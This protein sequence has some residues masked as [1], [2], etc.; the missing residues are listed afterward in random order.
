M[1]KIPLN[2]YPSHQRFGKFCLLLTS[3]LLFLFSSCKKDTSPIIEEP[4]INAVEISKV[5]AW[6]N[7]GENVSLITKSNNWLKKVSANWSKA[8]NSTVDSQT[9]YE[10]A[11]HNPNRIF[12]ATGTVEIKQIEKFEKRSLIR[13]LIFEDLATNKMTSCFM[14]MVAG[15]SY[16]IKKT[17]LNDLHYRDYQNY[18]GTVDFY[19]LDGN[20][21]NGWA[22]EQG[23]VT[24]RKSPSNKNSIG[25]LGNKK[26]SYAPIPCGTRQELHWQ[27]NCV[28]IDPIPGQGGEA[29]TTCTWS[30][31]YTNETLYCESDG[32][33]GYTPPSGGGGG[34]DPT[35][36]PNHPDSLKNPCDQATKLAQDAKFKQLMTN[37]KNKVTDN[38]EYGYF[39][40][41]NAAGSPENE[42]AVE[43]L[44]AKEGIDFT[45]STKID[46]FMHTHYTGLLSIFSAADIWSMAK[47]YKDG[48]MVNPKTFTVAVVTA[49]GTQYLL[50]IDDLSKF[51]TYSTSLASSSSIRILEQ[52]LESFPFAIKQTGRTP[53]QNEKAFIQ[54][55]QTSKT[56]L[57]LFKGN[58]NFTEWSPKKYESGQIKNNPCDGI[59]LEE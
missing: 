50:K 46:G 21:V 35:E 19:S 57:R 29:S 59:I 51:N 3:L 1:K 11:I 6:F 23:K 37:L 26:L 39:Y 15:E 55:L 17:P 7:K 16:D 12:V 40:K 44:T 18:T 36:P 20:F 9:V 58:T 24:H 10:V 5:K 33:G 2:H 25:M 30:P 41:N 32:N 8:Y 22:L 27:Q 54:F 38:K 53:D 56:G 43:G 49:S 14:V 13:L 31:Y 48:N 28:T 52:A 34:S 4:A 45:V 42:T 47:L